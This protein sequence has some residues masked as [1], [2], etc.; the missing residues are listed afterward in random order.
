MP[1]L[2]TASVK[3]RRLGTTSVAG[4]PLENPGAA[5][6]WASQVDTRCDDFSKC[7]R[8]RSLVRLVRFAW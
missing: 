7:F 5:Q 3:V 2:T 8:D 1:C 4:G 6:A